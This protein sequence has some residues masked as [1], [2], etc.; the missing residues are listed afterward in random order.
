MAADARLRALPS[1]ARGVGG[2]LGAQGEHKEGGRVAKRQKSMLLLV[3]ELCVE[4]PNFEGL[5]CKIR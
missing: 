5:K 2:I 4:S 1:R 3:S